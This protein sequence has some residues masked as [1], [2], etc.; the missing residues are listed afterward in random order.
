VK[1]VA[2]ENPDTPRRSEEP[3]R[4][5]N[6]HHGRRCERW[7]SLR[8]QEHLCP[9]G[10]CLRQARSCYLP[11][12]S[13][14]AFPF[15]KRPLFYTFS[16]EVIARS[17]CDRCAL[18]PVCCVS[19]RSATTSY[20]VW[21]DFSG[22]VLHTSCVSPQSLGRSLQLP[23]REAS[24]SRTQRSLSVAATRSHSSQTWLVSLSLLDHGQLRWASCHL[25][26][27][28]LIWLQTSVTT[29]WVALSDD[30]CS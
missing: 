2:P 13:A 4:G 18:D 30:V 22:A 10:F 7:L 23:W 16:G 8:P 12:R 3:A 6:T 27:F 17:E 5:R 14:C 21:A 28:S 25:F 11:P 19:G 24:S 20:F 1:I 29:A 15:S 9:L 26:M